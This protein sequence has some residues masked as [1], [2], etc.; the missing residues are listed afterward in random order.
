MK[1]LKI[2]WGRLG[3][4]L[5]LLFMAGCSGAIDTPFG[6]QTVSSLRASNLAALARI[7][8][9]SAQ[10]DG[11]IRIGLIADS[12]QNYSDLERV[13]AELNRQD[14]DFVVH[15]GDFTNIGVSSEF[16][17]FARLIAPLRHPLLVVIGNHDAVGAG[18]QLFEKLFGPFNQSVDFAG[19]RFLLYNSNS[20]EFRARPGYVPA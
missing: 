9:L 13:V 19:R 12:H 20:L 8:Q 17:A 10:K 2:N 15:L 11:L 7:D 5:A 1:N 3:G 14:L 16:D 4:V 6:T 18:P